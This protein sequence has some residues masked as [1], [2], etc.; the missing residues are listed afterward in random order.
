MASPY[1][2]LNSYPLPENTPIRHPDYEAYILVKV[3]NPATDV[4]TDLTKAI[5]LTTTADVLIDEAL[6]KMIYCEVRLLLVVDLDD[7]VLGIVTARDIMGEKPVNFASEERLPRG[8][9]RVAD[10][11]TLWRDVSVLHYSEVEKS[12]VGDIV[13][14]LKEAG[15]QHALV[16]EQDQADGGSKI[17]GI[18]STTYIGRKL[19]IEIHPTGATQSFAELEKALL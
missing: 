10:I 14:T 13:V 18:F 11:M 5:P 7:L 6:Q 4:M 16:V 12:T 8:K 1:T 3:S 19:G 9:I 17:R 15:R 2:I